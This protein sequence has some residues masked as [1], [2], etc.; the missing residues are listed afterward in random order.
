VFEVL[1]INEHSGVARLVRI[2]VEIIDNGSDCGAVNY[3]LNI[4]GSIV[5]DASG[6][7]V[8]P[9]VFRM[10][11]IWV[12]AHMVFSPSAHRKTAFSVAHTWAKAASNA[13]GRVAATLSAIERTKFCAR[14][15]D[16]AF[17]LR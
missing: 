3:L 11:K 10:L 17:T 13:H 1:A 15:R 9:G 8:I 16:R 12:V 14:F 5:V 2:T 6:F 4:R 7:D